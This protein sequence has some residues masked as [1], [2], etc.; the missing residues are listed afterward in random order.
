M[1]EDQRYPQAE[2]RG[3]QNI[4]EQSVRR[5]LVAQQRGADTGLRTGQS[6][7][8][9]CSVSCCSVSLPVVNFHERNKAVAITEAPRMQAP[10]VAGLPSQLGL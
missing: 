10:T 7:P 4:G 1:V 3:D 6:G 2:D 8:R 5:R 9:Q